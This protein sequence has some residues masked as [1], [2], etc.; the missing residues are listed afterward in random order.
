MN[1]EELK[2]LVKQHFNLQDASTEENFASAKLEDGT[3]ITNDKD[4]A[5]AMGDKIFVKKDGELLA[6]P[7]GDHITE[8]GIVL[9]LDAESIVVGLKK[10]DEEG[11]GSADLAEH[12][13]EKEIEAKVEEEMSSEDVAENFEKED[14]SMEEE[15]EEEVMEEEM[16]PKLEEIIEVIGEVVEEKMMEIKDKMKVVESKMKDMEEKMS[17]FSSEPA[18]EKTVPSAK[19][20]AVKPLNEK[21]YNNMLNFLNNK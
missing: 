6:A 16:A 1:R 9:T 20:S 4:S 19:F 10:P 13:P 3:E 18:E 7:E 5:L 12:A 2:A 17:S 21:R 11:E 15:K 14:E 8:S